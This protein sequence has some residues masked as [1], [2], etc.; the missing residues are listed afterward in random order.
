MGHW[1]FAFLLIT[2]IIIEEKDKVLNISFLKRSTAD[3]QNYHK[4]LSTYFDQTVSA[5]M[6]VHSQLNV[7]SRHNT[8]WRP[9]PPQH[10]TSRGSS[11]TAPQLRS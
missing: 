2:V 11:P 5:H 9:M 6:P 3:N 10:R 4:V 7:N 8:A 1:G